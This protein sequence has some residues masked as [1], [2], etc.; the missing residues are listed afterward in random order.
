MFLSITST[1]LPF[2]SSLSLSPR[3][4]LP[5]PLSPSS[6]PFLFKIIVTIFSVSLYFPRLWNPSSA[7]PSTCPIFSSGVYPSLFPTLFYHRRPP[8]SLLPC[9]PISGVQLFKPHTYSSHGAAFKTPEKRGNRRAERDKWWKSKS[10]N[11]TKFTLNPER[12]YSVKWPRVCKSEQILYD[13]PLFCLLAG[14][15][16]VPRFDTCFLS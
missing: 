7:C 14:I 13:Y 11:L 9:S 8:L 12:I 6:V 16:T 15:F 10:N 5:S 4:F 1:N 2:L 3:F